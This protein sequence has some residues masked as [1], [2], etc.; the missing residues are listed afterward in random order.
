MIT[1]KVLKFSRVRIDFSSKLCGFNRL[2]NERNFTN[3]NYINLFFLQNLNSFS[4]RGRIFN[5]TLSVDRCKYVIDFCQQVK[6]QHLLTYYPEC[7]QLDILKP[8][9]L[10]LMTMRP[11]MKIFDRLIRFMTINWSRQIDS[12]NH[13]SSA[14]LIHN[15]HSSF[16]IRIQWL[17]RSN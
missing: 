13:S 16:F 1:R 15:P 3:K 10:I 9:Q 8:G 14:Y 17:Y 12:I 2:F 6:D 5:Y 11:S 7:E 4:I